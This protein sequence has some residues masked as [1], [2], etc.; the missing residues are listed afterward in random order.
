MYLGDVITTTKKKKKI[1]E[2]NKQQTTTKIL[3]KCN[4]NYYRPSS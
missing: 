1:N 4:R 3:T 2:I